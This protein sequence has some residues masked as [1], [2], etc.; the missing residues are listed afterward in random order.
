MVSHATLQVAFLKYWHDGSLVGIA[1]NSMLNTCSTHWHITSHY[2]WRPATTLDDFG[3]VLG[4]PFGH[5]FWALTISQSQLWACVQSGF[6]LMKKK[7]VEIEGR[8]TQNPKPL[9]PSHLRPI[10]AILA[11]ESIEVGTHHFTWGPK[12]WVPSITWIPTWQHFLEVRLGTCVESWAEQKARPN[13][14]HK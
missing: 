13:P 5:F 11:V 14:Q 3:S 9:V 7:R 8:F 6:H 2:T 1:K 10:C 4:W 12:S